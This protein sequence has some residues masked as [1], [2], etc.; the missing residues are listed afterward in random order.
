MKRTPH[1][2]ERHEDESRPTSEAV[3][4]RTNAAEIYLDV[5]TGYYVFVGVRGRTHV[6]TVEGLHHT[7]FRTTQKNRIERLAIG[8]WERLIRAELPEG[9]K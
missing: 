6:F 8:K 3:E 9:L 5:E 7:S 2:Q 1:G 4:D